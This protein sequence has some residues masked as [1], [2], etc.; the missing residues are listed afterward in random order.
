MKIKPLTA[1]LL[2]QTA[3]CGVM[4]LFRNL[5]SGWMPGS[6]VQLASLEA[7]GPRTFLFLAWN[8]FLAWAPY[9]LAGLLP[10]S[11]SPIPRALLLLLWLLFFPNAPYLITDLIHLRPRPPIPL[12]Y[13]ALMMF[14]AAWMGLLLG[15]CSLLRVGI[16][17]RQW[18]GARFERVFS[19]LALLL[20]GFGVYLGRFLRW[21]SWDA[22]VRP[23]GL[24]ESIYASFTHPPALLHSLSITT[25]F[26]ALLGLGY[27]TIYF[28]S[29]SKFQ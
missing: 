25:L 27:F 22:L 10:V 7:W 14:S 13:D 3:F 24:L 19:T 5:Y 1:L 29:K 17:M 9:V 28:I 18:R 4:I 21:N 16:V 26:G 11:R 12:W 20:C 23:L 2:A 8:L 6:F 15:Y